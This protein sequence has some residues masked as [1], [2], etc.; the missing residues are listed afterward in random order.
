MNDLQ[1]HD[2]M[3][4]LNNRISGQERDDAEQ[5]AYLARW[6]TDHP[7]GD[8]AGCCFLICLA[9]AMVAATF[10]YI[11]QGDRWQHIML[12]ASSHTTCSACHHADP[13]PQTY[14]QYR[15]LHPNIDR[16][17]AALLRELR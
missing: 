12:L 4:R 2:E 6:S 15:R 17:D 11:K 8:I 14:K 9:I 10:S 16:A 13:V 1:R 7:H 3:A 5:A